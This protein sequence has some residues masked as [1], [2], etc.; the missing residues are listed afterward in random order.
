MLGCVKTNWVSGASNR[1]QIS[2]RCVTSTDPLRK[3]PG[4]MR[5]KCDEMTDRDVFLF[6]I[7]SPVATELSQRYSDFPQGRSEQFPPRDSRSWL[8]AIPRC[9]VS[10]V[11]NC[12]P[13]LRNLQSDVVVDF[14]GRAACEIAI[15]SPTTRSSRDSLER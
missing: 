3:F 14:R 11:S 8:Y 4:S 10:R 5:K 6:S 15:G 7:D 9:H 13:A 2:L 1:T 12:L